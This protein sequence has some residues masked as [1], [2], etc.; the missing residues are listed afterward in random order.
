MSDSEVDYPT[1]GRTGRRYN[2]VPPTSKFDFNAKVIGY[3]D[4]G[5]VIIRLAPSLQD[6]FRANIKASTIT[7]DDQPKTRH[8]GLSKE[9]EAMFGKYENE[10]SDPEA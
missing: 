1:R 4:E 3:T 10:K 7:W 9:K 8:Y 6:D 5:D 2:M